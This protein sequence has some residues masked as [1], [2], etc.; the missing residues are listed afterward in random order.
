MIAVVGVIAGIMIVLIGVIVAVILYK[1]CKRKQ[2]NVPDNKVSDKVPDKDP[3]NNI[4]DKGGDLEWT[5]VGR[6]STGPFGR[7]DGESFSDE[8]LALAENGPSTKIIV[9]SG[10]FIDAIITR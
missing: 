3:D 1:K 10:L 8:V 4:P 9:R 2:D 6:E 7:D 5:T